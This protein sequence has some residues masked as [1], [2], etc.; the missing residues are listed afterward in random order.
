[1]DLKERA[2]WTCDEASGEAEV[3]ILDRSP[4]EIEG[5]AMRRGMVDRQPFLTPYGTNAPADGR[6]KSGARVGTT[7]KHPLPDSTG[8][9]SRGL[10]VLKWACP[11]LTDTLLVLTP[12]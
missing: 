10:V 8:R 3:L 4:H 11:A 1:M 6:L 5:A 7:T 12:D 9:Q 2:G